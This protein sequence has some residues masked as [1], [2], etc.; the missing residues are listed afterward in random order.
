MVGSYSSTK[1]DCMNWIVMADL[2]TPSFSTHLEIYST[3]TCTYRLPPSPT[4]TILYLWESADY[5]SIRYLPSLLYRYLLF[6]ECCSF[7]WHYWMMEK[8]ALNNENGWYSVFYTIMQN[9]KC[10]KSNRRA[11]GDVYSLYQQKSRKIGS[12][13]RP[14]MSSSWLHLIV[15]W[16]AIHCCLFDTF[17]I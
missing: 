3:V 11:R 15:K 1:W 2:P 12:K 13:A 16:C 8:K 7:C 10:I 17:L 5:V 9:Q 6:Q 14:H 4:M